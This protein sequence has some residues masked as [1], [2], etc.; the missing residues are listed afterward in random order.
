MKQAKR[1]KYKRILLKLSGE[2][3]GGPTGLNI[4]PQAVR[5]MAGQIRAVRKLKVQIV[6]VVGG[7]NIFR[8]L[9]GSKRGMDRTTGDYMGMLATIINALAL[10]DALEKLKVPTRVLSAISISQVAEPFIRRRAVRHLEKGRVVI[11][12]GGTGN[13]YFSTDTTAALRANEI[14]VDVVLK[15]TKV[16]GIYDD[17]PQKN[18]KAKRYSQICYSDALRQ[19]LKVMDSTAFSLCMDN[20]MPIIVFN[21][22]QPNNLKRIILGEQI[23]TLVAD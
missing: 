17:D 1:P 8:G 16:D 2:A 4:N 9:S 19:R 12:A 13:P 20:K 3:L 15:A 7:G 14:G 18:P 11:F 5:S 22:S 21:F 23:G 10:Q 6:I